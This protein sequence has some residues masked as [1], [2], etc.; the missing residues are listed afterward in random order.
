MVKQ[1]GDGGD[2]TLMRG[3]APSATRRHSR[4]PGR[5]A[6]LP[7]LRRAGAALIAVGSVLLVAAGSAA[8]IPELESSTGANT[9]LN[10]YNASGMGQKIAADTWVD[11]ACKVYAPQIRS[12][13]PDGYWYRIA[14]PPWNNVYYAVAN[15]FRNGDIPGHPPYIHSTDWAVPDCSTLSA[16]APSPTPTPGP[17][18]VGPSDRDGDGVSPPVDC[19][20]TNSSVPPGAPEIP[21]NGL[22]DDC[23]GGDRPGKI[24]AL[25]AVNWK[26]TQSHLRLVRLR[27][28]DA[29]PSAQIAILCRG[30]CRFRTR[31]T[32]AGATGHTALL[33]LIPRRF[34][35]RSTL[36]VRITAPN[37]IGKVVRYRIL[38]HRIRRGQIPL[39]QRLCLPPGT[40]RPRRC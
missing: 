16:P 34:R 4:R 37:M 19:L 30:K 32:Q 8:A 18:P 13:N 27:V 7:R 40:T 15:T 10:P 35:P 33:R 21:A 3:Q 20:D 24:L 1:R 36:E 17:A 38:R 31:H 28:E 12:A 39:G 29:P 6:G 11:V 25:V 2:G 22:D 9:F 14:S 26:L 5:R 23:A